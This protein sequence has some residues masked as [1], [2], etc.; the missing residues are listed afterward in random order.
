MKPE[1]WVQIQSLYYAARERDSELRAGF[2]EE[3]YAQF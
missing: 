3:G 1:R 2:V